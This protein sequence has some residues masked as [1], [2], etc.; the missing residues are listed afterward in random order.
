M[1][2]RVLVVG[3]DGADWTVV[4]HLIERGCLP[5]LEALIREGARADLRSTLPTNSWAAWSTF[6][7]GVEPGRHG[8]YDFVE[9]NPA[10]PG[11]RV[12]VSSL[13]IRSPTLFQRL[14]DAG[15][16]VRVGNVPVTFPPSPVKGRMISGVAIPPGREFVYPPEWAEQLK[17]RAP[18]P[19]NGMEWTRFRTDPERLTAE[20]KRL[21][22]E[23]SDSFEALLEG[24]WD[25]GVC[26]IGRASCRERV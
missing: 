13:S 26:E 12:P 20:A 15:H 9:R 17:Q 4:E 19:V 16:E 1:T 22:E 24:Y 14:S 6:M 8:V 11:R 5:N 18:F 10:Q 7:T 21:V 3:W 2:E 23:R 25:V